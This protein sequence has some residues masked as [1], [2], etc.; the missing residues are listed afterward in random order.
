VVLLSSGYNNTSPGDGQGYLYVVDIANGNVLNRIA[1]GQGSTTSPSGFA[2]MSAYTDSPQTDNTTRY[3]YGGDLEGNLHRFDIGTSTP[4]HIIMAT[5]KDGSGVK[6]PITTRPEL[7]Y[8]SGNKVIFVGTGRF[9]G[10]SDLQNPSTLSPAGDWSYQATVYGL[11]DSATPLG[12]PRSST[13][14]VMQT[15]TDSGTS[16]S[17][18]RNTVDWSGDIGWALDLP[19]TGERVN[20]D[21]FLVRG[22]LVV[23]GNIPSTEACTA[24]GTSWLM[25]L[26]AKNGGAVRQTTDVSAQFFN[27]AMIAG[28]TGV[29]YSD[30]KLGAITTFTD[31]TKQN[32]EFPPAETG[33]VRR[34][35]W[36]EVPR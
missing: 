8:F 26:N 14:L 2:K 3:V 4:S 16:R 13:G 21:P 31:G 22:T 15:A 6:Q 34:V 5:L 18:T 1:T 12:D 27:A 19:G 7:G 24:G 10:L 11:K 30:G 25:F 20:V 23:A 28:I 9:L 35:G 29:A 36:R 33:A 32:N 17:V